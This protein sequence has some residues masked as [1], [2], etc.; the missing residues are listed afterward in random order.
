MVGCSWDKKWRS[1]EKGNE[2]GSSASLP[3][4]QSR[5]EWAVRPSLN[6]TQCSYC[7]CVS[8]NEYVETTELRGHTASCGQMCLSH[9]IFHILIWNVLGFGELWG[10]GGALHPGWVGFAGSFPEDSLRRCD[11]G[12]LQE[13]HCRRWGCFLTSTRK[14]ENEV[15]GH[16]V[17]LQVGCEKG[18]ITVMKRG[19]VTMHILITY[20]T[21]LD[22]V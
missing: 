6:I 8:W 7:T 13:L 17:S 16:W 12:D 14:L 20:H 5:E 21:L 1:L 19:V 4:T 15:S 18:R 22:C 3:W 11:A 10:S 2:V 9:P